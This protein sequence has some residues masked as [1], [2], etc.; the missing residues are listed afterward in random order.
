M[1]KPVVGQA[2]DAGAEGER[3]PTKKSSEMLAAEFGRQ[4]LVWKD[5]KGTLG[6]G[7]V[8]YPLQGIESVYDV[9]TWI[10]AKPA[11]LGIKRYGEQQTKVSKGSAR[12]DLAAAFSR[13][14]LVW[15]DKRGNLGFGNVQYPATDTINRIHVDGNWEPLPNPP[16]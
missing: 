7:N 16:L 15:Q 5:S 9:D 6:F 14:Y 3:M 4:C 2:P 8:Q 10:E 13:R 1:T 12:E 11:D